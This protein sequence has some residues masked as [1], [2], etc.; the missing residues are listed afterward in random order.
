MCQSWPLPWLAAWNTLKMW[1]WK[2]TLEKR[3]P[4]MAIIDAERLRQCIKSRSDSTQRELLVS[5]RWKLIWIG[6]GVHKTVFISFIP[7]QCCNERHRSCGSGQ[8]HSEWLNTLA[9]LHLTFL[10][11]CM[12]LSPIYMTGLRRHT[13]GPPT[14]R[15]LT[16]WWIQHTTLES[17]CNNHKIQSDCLSCAPFR[18][19][20]ECL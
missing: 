5:M 8:N 20:W 15:S 13:H 14:V 18:I 10:Y 19:H 1:M 9:V 12:S 11:V 3:R 17:S 16:I 7:H 4:T 6:L 2:E